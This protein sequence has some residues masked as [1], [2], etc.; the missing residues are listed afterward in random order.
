VES[1][2]GNRGNKFGTSPRKFRRMTAALLLEREMR[3]FIPTAVRRAGTAKVV[4]LFAD[5]TPRTVE[6]WSDGQNL[7]SAPA[8]ISMARHIPELRAKVMEWMDAST[9][10]SGNDPARVL[11]EIQRLLSSRA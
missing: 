6:N 2:F 9:G 8:L 7:P 3:D 11:N 1:S 4:A 5:T 10:D